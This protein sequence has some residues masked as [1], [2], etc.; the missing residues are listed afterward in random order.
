MAQQLSA[1]H[2]RIIAETEGLRVETLGPH[3]RISLRARGDLAAFEAPLGLPLPDRIGQRQARDRIEALKLGPD[4][5]LLLLHVDAV[6][7]TLAALSG[8]YDSHPHSAVD[9]SG[10]EITFL[11]DGRLAAGLL[12][13]GCPRDLASIPEGAARRTVFDGATVTLWHDAPGRYRMDVWN[14]FAPFLA[15]TLR[16]GCRELAAEAA[17]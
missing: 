7:A 3:G 5:W 1:L 4:E 15:Q 16:R 17:R 9:L 12:S 2:P 11:I 8:V 6:A 14:S 10:R 13:I